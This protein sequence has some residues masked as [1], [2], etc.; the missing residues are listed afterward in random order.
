MA[1]LQY[2]GQQSHTRV[3]EF[4]ETVLHT[5]KCLL[6]IFVPESPSFRAWPVSCH[7]VCQ[8]VGLIVDLFSG[9]HRATGPVFVCVCV[10]TITVEMND[11]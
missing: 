10:R 2:F 5:Y 9:L 4:H 3:H 11:L 1:T 7:L 8:M 6:R